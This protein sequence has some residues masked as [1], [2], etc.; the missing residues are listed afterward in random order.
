MFDM[1]YNQSIAQVEKKTFD[2][3]LIYSTI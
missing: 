3:H 1:S 2:K